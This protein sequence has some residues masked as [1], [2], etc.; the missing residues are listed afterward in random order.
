MN[1]GLGFLSVPLFWITQRFGW[2]GLFLIVGGIG[3]AVR[4][5]LVGAL[6]QPGRR[7]RR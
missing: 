5:R 7:A 6:S 4:V 1:F 3:I 2:R